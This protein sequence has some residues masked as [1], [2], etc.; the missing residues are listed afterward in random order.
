MQ[1]ESAIFFAPGRVWALVAGEGGSAAR[2]RGGSDALAK[3]QTT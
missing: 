3:N 1:P 2:V